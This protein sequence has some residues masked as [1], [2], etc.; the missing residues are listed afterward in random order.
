MQ[1][2]DENNR[3]KHFY[4]T[5]KL[6][7]FL[8]TLLFYFSILAFI[9]GF[10]FIDVMVGNWYQQFMPNLN[11]ASIKDITFT[12]SLNGYA[13]TSLRTAGDSSYILKTTDS[14][15][16]WSI[17]FMH[18]RAFVRVEFINANTGFTNAFTRIYK[19]TNSGENWTPINLPSIFGDDMFVLSEDTIWLA[20]SES[21]TGGVYFTSTGGTSW[22]P[23]LNLGS[24]NPVKIY[25]FNGSTGYIAKNT[26]S[27]YIRKT[28]NSGVNW[29]TI[30]NGRGF[31]DIFF[32]NTLTGWSAFDSVRKTTNGGINWQT[33]ILP[34][35]FGITTL[36]STRFSNINSDTIWMG[37]GSITFPNSQSRGMLFRTT[38]SGNNWFYQIPDTSIHS[39]LYRNVQ[40]VDKYKGWAYWSSGGI[41]T[42]NG[43]DTTFLG[44]KQISSQIPKDYKLYQNYP[45]PF[46][47]RTVIGYQLTFSSYVSIKVYDITGKEVFI[48]VNQEQK[49]GT[50][51]VDFPGYGFSS[52]VYFY[53]LIVDSK[54]IDTKKMILVK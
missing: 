21:L 32:V 39:G 11:G 30:V 25:M 3:K 29:D 23:Q 12:D 47:P 8:T 52:G 31:S 1:P 10:N 17:K 18:N 48:L 40:F 42:T 2:E 15:N 38:N 16:N 45:N 35:G 6:V 51:Q 34:Y 19:T 43:D 33:Q 44:I 14:G 7:N 4:L 24:Q 22:T 46:N 50:Y 9:I 5:N 20:M 28:T 27:P 37:G 36:Y 13:V 54:L 41:H 53:S 26:G 49:T